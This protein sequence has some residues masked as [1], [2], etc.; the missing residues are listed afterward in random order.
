MNSRKPDR[1]TRTGDLFTFEQELRNKGYP[2]IAGLDEAGRGPLAGPVVAAAVIFQQGTVIEGVNDSK[3]LS[4]DT[5]ERLFG[6]IV[7][8][9]LGV[10]IGLA[11]NTEI[12][13]LNI[14]NATF[15]A[16]DRAIADLR[17]K[18]DLLLVDGNIFRAGPASF[19]IP[20]QTRIGGDARDFSIAAA[21]IIAKVAR[22][23]LMMEYD[24]QYPGFGFARHKGY[25]TRKHREA[26]AR[27]GL[28]PIHR[29]S[30][31]ISGAGSST[32]DIINAEERDG[33]ESASQGSRRG[34]DCTPLPG[35]LRISGS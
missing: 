6:D 27:L 4:A 3:K 13:T 35:T 21:S 5:R 15:L 30:F 9:A 1:H 28:C 19:A 26:I 2:L 24:S 7:R 22:D 14:L 11:E 20:W 29:R 10:G 32:R 17:Q 23:R 31:A 25:G 12:D 34:I 18:P 8:L 16:M 33:E